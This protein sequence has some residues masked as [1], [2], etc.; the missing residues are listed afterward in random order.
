[1]IGRR[2]LALI[3]LGV[4]LALAGLASTY[5]GSTDDRG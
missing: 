3:V 5:P 4:A 1:M 2:S